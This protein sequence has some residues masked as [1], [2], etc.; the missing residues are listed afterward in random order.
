MKYLILLALLLSCRAPALLPFQPP[1][2][3]ERAAVVK[4]EGLLVAQGT[5][6]HVGGGRVYTAGHVCDKDVGFTVV[7][8]AGDR[9]ETS[10]LYNRVREAGDAVSPRDWCVLRVEEWEDAEAFFPALPVSVLPPVF[11]DRLHVIGYPH[12]TLIALEGLYSGEDEDV[13]GMHKLSIEATSGI[14]GGPVINEK[15]RVVGI[16]VADAVEIKSLGAFVP[17]TN[18]DY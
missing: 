3:Q 5:G 10:I 4:V 14:S 15:G 16:F 18:V 1:V 2:A 8:A 12:G 11:G 7:D 17:V 9:H 6:F 13:P